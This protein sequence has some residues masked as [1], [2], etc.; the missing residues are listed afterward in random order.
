MILK[1]LLRFG[2]VGA[3]ATLVHMMIGVTLI[4]SGWP[5]LLANPASFVVAFLVNFMGHFGFSFA[6]H[7]KDLSLSLKRFALVATGGFALNEVLLFM[8]I[9]SGAIPHNASLI[10]STGTAAVLTFIVSRSWADS[11]QFG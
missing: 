5:A 2:L 4:H 6:G 9:R 7:A 3:L 8:L 11:R 10:L 1:H